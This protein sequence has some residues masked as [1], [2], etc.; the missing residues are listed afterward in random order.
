MSGYD[1]F[2]G[3]V[4]SAVW[5]FL[6]FGKYLFSIAAAVYIWSTKTSM[7]GDK[8]IWLFML[9]VLCFSPVIILVYSII[10]WLFNNTAFP[11]IS[12]GIS[13]I[14]F[15]CISFFVGVTLAVKLKSDAPKCGLY[16]TAIIYVISL[17]LGIIHYGADFLNYL[18][19][20]S[21]GD[22][23]AYVELHEVAYIIGLYIIYFLIISKKKIVSKWLEVLSIGLFLIACKRIGIAAVVFI[24]TYSTIF[25]RSKRSNKAFFN[26]LAGI[27]LVIVCIL[28]VAFSVSDE[29]TMF[30]QLHGIDMMGR[31]IIYS[32]F[33][34]FCEFDIR[35]I[36]QGV[37]FVDRQFDYTTRA[38]LYRM[39]S[40]RALHNDYM[41]MYIEIG[42]VG[43]VVWCYYWG[44]Y[45]IDI[46]KRRFNTETAFLCLLLILYT[47]ITY[48]TDNTEGYF[49]YQ[50][51]LSLLLTT[52]CQF[53]GREVMAKP[54]ESLS[55][56]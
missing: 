21:R 11:Y 53:S 47:F 23:T 27:F 50:L 18:N 19:P 8:K 42:F 13:T 41:K 14:L 45:L 39:V 1:I 4:R 28:Y 7:C 48:T 44:I 29:L 33:R 40:I 54:V 17:L 22:N 35:F 10:P 16:A 15:K 38:D 3:E 55:S 25:Y 5:Y 56:Q 2:Y 36:G 52:I 12:R 43:F 37:G 9:K 30:L 31:D 49:N 51:H 32:Y 6:Y 46:I 24:F 34:Q 26:K 20:I